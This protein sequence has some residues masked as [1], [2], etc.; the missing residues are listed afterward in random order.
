MAPDT[1]IKDSGVDPGCW[2]KAGVKKWIAEHPDIGKMFENFLAVFEGAMEDEEMISLTIEPD[3]KQQHW[4]VG[5]DRSLTL[6]KGTAWD[7]TAATGRVRTWAGAPD[8]M[9]WGKYAKAFI[10]HDSA[11]AEKY[12]SYKLPFADVK[13]GKLVAIERGLVAARGALAGA[14]GGVSLQA[15]LEKSQGTVEELIGFKVLF[16]ELATDKVDALA[17]IGAVLNAK[18]KEKLANAVT[19]I[20]EVLKSAE[21]PTDGDG[22]G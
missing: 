8:N 11:D 18:N 15:T 13:G 9:D 6:V 21:K 2:D 10:V 12:G 22:T 5:G 16:E 19:L 20:N 3:E 14:R 1:Q 4:T 17:K 7:A